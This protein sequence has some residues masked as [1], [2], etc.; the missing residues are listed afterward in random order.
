MFIVKLGIPIRATSFRRAIQ[1]QPE[2]IEVWATARRLSWVGHRR[3]HF[4]AVEVTN[5]SIPPAEHAEARNIGV[6]RAHVGTRVLAGHVRNKNKVP[7]AAL[8]LVFDEPSDRR[9]CG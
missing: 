7:K 1:H 9:T 4:A 5:D 8:L 3:A 2:R 6:F